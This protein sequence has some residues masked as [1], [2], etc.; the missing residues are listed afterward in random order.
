MLAGDAVQRGAKGL[1]SS[2]SDFGTGSSIR[3]EDPKTSSLIAQA[4]GHGLEPHVV[5]IGAVISEIGLSEGSR[6]D[7]IVEK[8]LIAAHLRLGASI[9]VLR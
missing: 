5:Q 7:R 2:N 9:K 6:L 4:K 8:L 1:L 3:R